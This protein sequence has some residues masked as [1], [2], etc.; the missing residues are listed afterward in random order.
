MYVKSVTGVVTRLEI[1]LDCVGR[2]WFKLQQLFQSAT[3]CML[4]LCM[5]QS[6]SFDLCVTLEYA[7]SQLRVLLCRVY[8][9]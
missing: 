4:Q 7:N 1:L 6:G 9:N 2:W 8:D 5:A 3:A